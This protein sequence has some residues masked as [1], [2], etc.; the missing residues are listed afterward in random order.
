MYADSLVHK[1][2]DRGLLRMAV[3]C[4]L[5]LICSLSAFGQEAT[6]VG[7]I[8]DQSGSVVPNVNITA[9]NVETGQ[10][11]TITSNG[12]GQYV[13]PALH[14][15][16]YD[17]TAEATGFKKSVK[18]G[19]VL[20]VGDRE[21]VDF[22]MSVGAIQQSVTVE[23]NA[24][25]VQSDTGEVSSVINGRQI[26]QLQTNGRS[27]YT[28]ANLTP[29]AS[30]GQGDFQIPTP[31]GG[32][33]N[34]SFNGQRVAHNLYLVDGAETADR[35]GSGAIV[36]PSL[37]AI[38]EFRELTSNYSAEYG[39]S[40]AGTVSTV[41]KSGTKQLHAGA[42]W[43][44]RNDY[45]NARN[46][47]SPRQTLTGGLNAVPELRFNTWGFNV[48]G[49]VQF[50]HTD[51]PKTFFF[52]NMEWRRL[53]TGGSI[54]T[55]V[56]F[57][58]TYG[59]D[60]S[61]AVAFSIANPT[62]SLF[63]NRSG[64]NPGSM[65][66]PC[67]N[68]VSSSVTAKFNAAGVPLST[69][70]ASGNVLTAGAFPGNVI[71]ASLLDSNAQAL[72]K[73]GIFPAPTSNN[74]FIGGG[75][76][77]TSVKEELARVDHTFSDKFS[78]YGHWISEQIL[79]T[80]I[81][82]RWSGGANLPTVGDTFGNPSY[83]ATIH[84]T[85]TISP[86]L[87]NE[88][89]FNYDGNRINMLP[90]GNYKIPSGFAQH[91]Y[92]P[93]TTN[94]IPVINLNAGGRTGARFDANWNPWI[95]TA[96]D[97]Q[98]R[99]DVSWTKGAHQLK[100]G[101][102]WANFRKAQPLQVNTQG[103]FSFNGNFTGFDFADFLLGLSNS[104]NEAAL[105][106]TRH[107]N[108]VSWAAYVQDNWRATRRLTLNLGL[109]WDGIPHTSE[110]NGQMSNFIPSL[111]SS[112]A[113]PVFANA[114]ATQICSGVGI[115][116]ASCTAAS[117]GLSAS[118]VP[119]LA[120]LLF[121]ANGLGVPGK[122]PGVTNGLVNNHWNNWGPR[123]GFA[124]DLT[125][126]GKTIVRGGFGAMYE[127]IQGNDM[128]QAGGNNLF[129]AQPTVNNVSL[130]D[131]HI[132]VDASNSN[133]STA[134]LPVTVNSIT[135]LNPTRYK[136]PV[137]YQY[138]AGVQ[139]QLAA[140]T[141][142]SVAYVGNQNRYQSNAQ[143]IDLPNINLLNS[144]TG[145]NYNSSLPFLGYHS[146][147]VDQNEV[148]SHYNSM[149]VEL[150]SNLHHGLQI[151]A[152]YTLARSIDPTTGT[153]GDGFDLNTPSNPYLGWRGDVGPSVFDRT[154]VAFVNFIYDLPIFRNSQNRF[155]KSV[156]GGW[157]LSGIVTMESGVPIN[158]GVTGS[159]ICQ[160]L[161]NCSVRPNLVGKI[162]YPKTAATV[163]NS[164]LNS[165]QWFDPT[166]F[167]PQFLSGANANVRGFGNLGH[168]A[169]RG[170]GRDNWNLAM[171]KT[172]AFGERLHAELR[173]ESFNTWN[174]TQFN[175]VNTGIGGSEAGRITSAFDPRVF[176]LGAKVIF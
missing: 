143:E 9:T 18:N 136:N 132:G 7:T 90:L 153:G 100:I 54:R 159:N 96:D 30:S 117:P 119:A 139:Q 156:L 80:D 131:P 169:L 138:S 25:Q 82:T 146:I 116:N 49:P 11:R 62:N 112:A 129:G 85:Y 65:H 93:G 67:S 135:E 86:T 29:G 109:R 43:F 39:L 97:Y 120:G 21:R 115:P 38:A 84:T 99:D 20:S 134:S 51:N 15:G 2:K 141:V 47:F 149:Q 171:F 60:L 71:P 105:K 57:T 150:H 157:Q 114:N 40:S 111:Y 121:Y 174:H 41:L 81:P 70:D 28:L 163:N 137:S 72:L 19:V 92:F 59:G 175:G 104:Y 75:N 42:W 48:G 6:I 166:A 74:T 33:Q 110:I 26:T 125:G 176:Q 170:P 98:I 63:N 102:S 127:R 1:L 69:C 167:A 133:I 91:K 113:Q 152:A 140:N 52:Y 151:Q 172:F 144:L 103:N 161:T 45:L 31:M 17:V 123:I 94:V 8:T 155:A 89:S 55:G 79:Q 77:P 165:M 173:A 66:T 142:V 124:Y 160:T 46:F 4:A 122:T 168:N 58:S 53:V 34:I 154:H 78:V 158:L 128:Y 101:G 88:A 14:I 56:P 5:F 64:N 35:G 68:A 22:A 50:K 87:L 44:G 36:M 95:N 148:N 16:H 23:A 118:S 3:F 108:S 24:I 61:Q 164:T 32:D 130:S 147:K 162:A 76:S 106:D 13:L 126:S 83:S 145:A 37:D 27:L 107:W 12:E 73:A 10:S